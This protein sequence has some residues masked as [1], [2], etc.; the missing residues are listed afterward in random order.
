MCVCAGP[1]IHRL[2]RSTLAHCEHTRPGVKQINKR[3]HT[4]TQSCYLIKYS[5]A[6]C[7]IIMTSTH[8]A[9]VHHYPFSKFFLSCLAIICSNPQW[10]YYCQGKVLIAAQKGRVL[11]RCK[12]YFARGINGEK[13]GFSFEMDSCTWCLLFYLKLALLFIRHCKLLPAHLKKNKISG[14]NCFD[15]KQK[16]GE[17]VRLRSSSGANTTT[18]LPCIIHGLLGNSCL[19]RRTFFFCC[20]YLTPSA[21]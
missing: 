11:E 9:L 6:L 18:T 17:S 4:H 16:C 21:L 20:L 3:S 14:T 7:F 13:R 2:C 8:S 19:R 15:L 10:A 5:A 1:T 12:I